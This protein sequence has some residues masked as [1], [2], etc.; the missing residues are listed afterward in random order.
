MPISISQ[1]IYTV[2]I[3]ADF[4]VEPFHFCGAGV[5]RSE[6]LRTE[7]LPQAAPVRSVRHQVVLRVSVAKTNLGT[8]TDPRL[9]LWNMAG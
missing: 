5:R 9:V 3:L 2:H 1:Y 7:P 6:K 4:I 8:L